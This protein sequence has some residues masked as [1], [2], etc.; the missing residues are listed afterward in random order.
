MKLKITGNLLFSLGMTILFLFL[1]VVT[2]GY[3]YRTKLVP[4]VVLVPGLIAAALQFLLDLREALRGE[5][6]AK[7]EVAEE[8]A[9]APVAETEVVKPGK[10][11]KKEKLT[12]QEKRRREWIAVGWLFLSV[13]L[14]AVLGLSVAIPVFVIAYMRFYGRE[15]W[16]LSIGIAALMWAFVY[17]VFVWGMRSQL[18]PGLIL[19][20]LER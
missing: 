9:S 12:P 4:M 6:P 17:V 18:H 2:M 13:A 19:E 14:I 11:A 3:G 20:W 16:R 8:Q 15:S 7:P 1:L 10:G 5:K